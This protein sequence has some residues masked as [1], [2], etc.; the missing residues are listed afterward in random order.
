MSEHEEVPP[1]HLKSLLAKIDP[2]ILQQLMPLTGGVITMMFTDIVNSTAIK[3]ALGDETYFNDVLEPHNR[4]VRERIAAHNGREL[5]TIG[6]A[7]LVGFAL[8]RQA[9]GCAV[10]IQQRLAAAPILAEGKPL[11]VRI[12]LHTG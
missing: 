11:E 9:V 3:A 12:G 5:K 1:E 8:P 2:A 6:D 4:V 10:D 7:F